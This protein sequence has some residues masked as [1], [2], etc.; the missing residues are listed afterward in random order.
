MVI[1]GKYKIEVAHISVNICKIY[2]CV[3]ET[4]HARKKLQGL[5]QEVSQNDNGSIYLK[6]LERF[7]SLFFLTFTKGSHFCYFLIASLN[8][9]L[10]CWASN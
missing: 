3:N 6:I 2:E 9:I 5:E 7:F 10:A 4:Q 1:R 8:G